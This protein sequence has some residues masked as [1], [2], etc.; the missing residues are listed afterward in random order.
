MICS[1]CQKH[2]ASTFC[3]KRY[4]SEYF[5][6]NKAKLSARNAEYRQKNADAVA[7]Y[8][9]E[10]YR[11]NKQK[12]RDSAKKRR[13]KL[14]LLVIAAY[15]GECTCC[16]E[17]RPEFLSIDHINGGGRQ[18]RQE[19]IAS[20]QDFYQ[21]LKK[22]NFPKDNYRLL[23]H[24]CNQALGMFGYC[25]HEIERHGRQDNLVTDQSSAHC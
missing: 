25:P 23:C 9:A 6:Q 15:G 14:K 18:H 1:F 8:N 2:D 10:Y 3:D 4:A 17:K 16:Q 24:N 12:Y 7:Q 11:A 21:W 22:N 5:K 19:L 13:Q 20:G